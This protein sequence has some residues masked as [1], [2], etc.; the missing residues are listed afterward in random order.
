MYVYLAALLESE[1]I[2]TLRLFFLNNNNNNI[3]MKQNEKNLKYICM[4][5]YMTFKGKGAELV[6]LIITEVYN[7]ENCY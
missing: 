4:Y 3:R 7:H 5:I 2:T 1:I 6:R